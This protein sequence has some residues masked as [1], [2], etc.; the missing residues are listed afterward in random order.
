[1]ATV[2]TNPLRPAILA[3]ARSSVLE[4]T[5]S[6]LGLTRKVVDRFVAGEAEPDV[7]GNVA[8]LLASGRLV[9]VDYL[10]EDTTD[11][12]QAA[13]TVRAYLSLI[14]AYGRLTVPEHNGGR[15]LEV[16]LKLSALG[17]S[18]PEGGQQVALGHARTICAAA[19]SAGVWVTVDAEDHTTTDSTLA[20]VRELRQEIGRASCRERV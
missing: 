16:S 9:S 2:L 5:V 20:I 15:P 13:A 8:K 1:M 19:E 4:R 17:Q 18:L 11:A 6:R 10:G 14:T 3:A 12:A 7:V